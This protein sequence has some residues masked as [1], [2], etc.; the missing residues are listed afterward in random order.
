MQTRK[1]RWFGRDLLN[2]KPAL[3]TLMRLIRVIYYSWFTQRKSLLGIQKQ[4]T[5]FTPVCTGLPPTKFY[6][7]PPMF[8]KK[9]LSGFEFFLMRMPCKASHHI[10]SVL[11]PGA[12]RRRLHS[13]LDGTCTWLQ[14]GAE[15][16]PLHDT[17]PAGSGFLRLNIFGIQALWQFFD[18]PGKR[19]PLEALNSIISACPRDLHLVSSPSGPQQ[20]LHEWDQCYRWRVQS[21]Q[22]IGHPLSRR[23]TS[24]PDNGGW[25][26]S[27][28]FTAPLLGQEA[29]L[30]VS[31]DINW[32]L[33][34]DYRKQFQCSLRPRAAV[35]S[36]WTPFWRTSM[37]CLWCN[38][39]D[40]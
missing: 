34:W 25:L 28:V 35:Q 12:S 20:E 29:A 33:G 14:L 4:F 18:M 39:V 5:Q 17:T 15:F 6:L 13:Y 36:T 9:W 1:S 26:G 21:A 3:P 19:R 30:H 8:V 2:P 38:K 27:C 22:E 24:R 32:T 40:D 37:R 16:V 31:R 7:F 23:P 11:L 10:L